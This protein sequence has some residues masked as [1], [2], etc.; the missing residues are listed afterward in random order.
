MSGDGIKVPDDVVAHTYAKRCVEAK[1][2][3]L[4]A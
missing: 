2:A 4:I 3:E 1:K